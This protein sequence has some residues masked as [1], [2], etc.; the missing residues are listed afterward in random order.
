MK[1]KLLTFA[2]LCILAVTLAV[3]ASGA[4]VTVVPFHYSESNPSFPICGLDVKADFST[5]GVLVFKSSGAS[6]NAGE[7]TAVW[8]NPSTGKSIVIHGANMFM[9]SA[10]IDNGDGTIS[11]V[12]SASGTYIVKAAHGAPL[13]VSAGRFVARVTFDATTGNLIS[14]EL[15]SVDGSPAPVNPPADSSCDSIVAALT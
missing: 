10:P 3:T 12:G 15:L 2:G 13:S 4:A 5:T 1:A 9:N 6:I 14:V 7:F 11:F 8:T